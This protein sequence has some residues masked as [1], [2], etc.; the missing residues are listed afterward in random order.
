MRL[1]LKNCSLAVTRP[2]QLWRWR[3]K[4]FYWTSKGEFLK[5]F[6]RQR[7]ILT[8][9]FTFQMHVYSLLNVSIISSVRRTPPRQN[10]PR[11]ILP[12]QIPTRKIPPRQISPRRSS[13][14]KIFPKKT[15]QHPL[16]KLF[17]LNRC[18]FS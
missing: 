15:S 12:R 9:S 8:L 13:P 4:I 11:K 10:S 16:L 18:F 5:H 17:L 1:D 14:R 7:I 6:L 2:T 3:L